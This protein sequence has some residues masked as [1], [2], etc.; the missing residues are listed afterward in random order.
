[1]GRLVRS[2]PCCYLLLLSSTARTAAQ[3][4]A[5]SLSA[6]RQRAQFGSFY[7]SAYNSSTMPGLVKLLIRNANSL[8]SLEYY[9]DM[10]SA[11]PPKVNASMLCS[12]WFPW[13]LLDP[14]TN[15]LWPDARVCHGH[16]HLHKHQLTV[17]CA[18]L[19][20]LS[21]FPCGY[22]PTKIPVFG[23]AFAALEKPHLGSNFVLRD[24][25]LLNLERQR[26]EQFPAPSPT[27]SLSQ[28]PRTGPFREYDNKVRQIAITM[29]PPAP[30]LQSLFSQF[31]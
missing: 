2:F 30:P 23:V 21:S 28:G 24:R 1:M 26:S 27:R 16:N 25:G 19:P 7:I 6:H 9:T 20:L 14:P 11:S 12:A 4:A 13:I 10:W 31:R 3:H 29:P 17:I 5:E 18:S 8:N 22:P 15:V